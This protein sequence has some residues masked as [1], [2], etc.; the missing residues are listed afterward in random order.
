VDRLRFGGFLRILSFAFFLALPV[1][2]SANSP[3]VVTN[4]TAHQ[5]PNTGTVQITY[6]VS[7][8]DGDSLAT[9][10]VCSSDNGVTFDL[11]PVTV[12]GDIRLPI[13]PGTGKQITW[14]AVKDYPGRF[15][16]QVVAKVVVSDGPSIAGPMALVPGGSFTMG[17]P[18]AADQQPVHPVSVD[19]FYIDKFEVTNAEFEAFINAGG[20]STQAFWS[21]SG[22][23]WR[24]SMN[25]TAP[26]YWTTGQYN[27]GPSWPGF[28]VVGVSWYEAE[29]YARY[30]AKR[31]PTEAEWEKAARSTDSRTYPW[32]SGVDGSRAN[33]LNSGDP[34]TPWS[35]PVAFFDGRLHPSPPFQTTDSPGPHGEY[36]QAGNVWE[37]VQDWYGPDY[38]A[39]SPASNPPGPIQGTQKVFRG[40]GWD[41]DV[42]GPGMKTYYRNETIP[43]QRFSSIGFRCAR[44]P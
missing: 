25:V 21:E 15:W 32:G 42:A 10:L 13:T 12:S 24:T 37:W 44:N 11:Y 18:D 6:D 2:T 33:Y 16:S 31:L 43:S 29:A 8:V 30:A 19:S 36:D 17:G 34:F 20:Y 22:W 28:P 4:V 7:D 14:N 9:S 5:I 40:G 26:E 38:Y 3:P 41:L 1:T 35:T 23:M 39:A 27:S